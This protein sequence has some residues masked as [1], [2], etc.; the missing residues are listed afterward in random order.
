MVQLTDTPIFAVFREVSVNPQM[1]VKFQTFESW[2]FW[3]K[4]PKNYRIFDKED[5]SDCLK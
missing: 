1:S 5:I 3:S 4:S 2:L